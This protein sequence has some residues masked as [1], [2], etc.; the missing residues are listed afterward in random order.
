MRGAADCNRGIQGRF[1]R[2]LV[3][4]ATGPSGK[5][6]VSQGL[7]LGHELT[8]FARDPSALAIKD[9]RLRVIRGDVLDVSSI[10]AAMSAQEAVVCTL[11][12]GRNVA[13]GTML[14]TGVAN[15][16]RTMK[17]ER[18][19][20]LVFLSSLGVGGSRAPSFFF[21]AL[22]RPSL[23]RRVFEDKERA[24]IVIRQSDIDWIIVRPPRLTDGPPTGQFRVPLQE[25]DIGK[26]ISRADLASFMLAQLTKDEYLRKTPA[27]SN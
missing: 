26:D 1:M 3:F 13:A 7:A 24:E 12:T 10:E 9:T 5:H 22:L 8:A 14:S 23:L 18:V 4:G 27:V 25:R 2:V 19:R 17:K 6:V 15:I 11:G 16:I 21:R 20:R